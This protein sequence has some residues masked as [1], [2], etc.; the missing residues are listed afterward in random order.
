MPPALKTAKRWHELEFKASIW[1]LRLFLSF[2][3]ISL[4]LYTLLVH[5]DLLGSLYSGCILLS[6]PGGVLA[7]AGFNFIDP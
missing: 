4:Q 5:A 3:I 2:S 7:V 1:Y 6:D